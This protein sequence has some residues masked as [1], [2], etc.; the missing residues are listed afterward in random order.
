MHT[1]KTGSDMCASYKYQNMHTWSN[2]VVFV[3]MVTPKKQSSAIVVATDIQIQTVM[4]Q[5]TF[6]EI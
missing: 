6:R 5:L 1:A 4:N 2:S 3:S